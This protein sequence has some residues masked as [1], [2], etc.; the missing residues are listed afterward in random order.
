VTQLAVYAKNRRTTA[1]VDGVVLVD[2]KRGKGERGV[3]LGH[4]FSKLLRLRICAGEQLLQG[5]RRLFEGIENDLAVIA[6][7]P[8]FRST[9]ARR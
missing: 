1:I 3:V 7:R 4:V 5:S 8:K 2:S 6:A 9:F